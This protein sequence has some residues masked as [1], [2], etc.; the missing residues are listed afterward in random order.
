MVRKELILKLASTFAKWAEFHLQVMQEPV[1]TGEGEEYCETCQGACCKNMP[2]AAHPEQ[3][4]APDKKLLVKNIAAALASGQW[5]VDWWEGSPTGVEGMYQTHYL[6]PAMTGHEGR[7]YHG[8]WP[9]EGECV[10]LGDKGCETEEHPAEC[11]GLKADT[12]GKCRE[13]VFGKKDA[14]IAWTPYQDE[15]DEAIELLERIAA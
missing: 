2:G 4:G 5:S 13:S 14:A 15:I 1:G 11:R 12:A 10:F 3:F 7:T 8:A 9:G 6:R